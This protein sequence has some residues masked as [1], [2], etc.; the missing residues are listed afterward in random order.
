MA[1]NTHRSIID[2]EYA[3]LFEDTRDVYLRCLE[4]KEITQLGT[5]LD[6]FRAGLTQVSV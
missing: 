1:N 6:H 2:R 5:R 3:A 4:P